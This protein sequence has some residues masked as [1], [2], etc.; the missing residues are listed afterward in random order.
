MAG[1]GVLSNDSDVDGDSLTAVLSEGPSNGSLV[2]N[3][4][5]AFLYTPNLG[6]SGT[7]HFAYKANDG[8]LDSNVVIVS[9]KVNPGADLPP[10][11][12]NDEFTTPENQAL[13]VPAP[14]ILANDVEPNGQQIRAILQKRPKHGKISLK[15][16]GSFVYTPLK[17]FNGIDSFTY[18]ASDGM[19]RSNFATVT[20][21]VTPVNTPPI[22]LNNLY[23]IRINKTLMVAAAGVLKNDTDADGD[24][25][26]ALL[27]KGP[28]HGNLSLSEDGSFFYTP[29]E[30]FFGYD[31]FT[32]QASDGTLHSNS[33]TVTIHVNRP[34]T[35]V[36]DL[37]TVPAS[38][39]ILIPARA[40][41]SIPIQFTF[42]GG[43]GFMNLVNG[44]PV[45]EPVGC[46]NKVQ[47]SEGFEPATG[48]ANLAFDARTGEYSY[49][50]Q[51]KPEW[52]G[53]CRKLTVV[54][55]DG[56]TYTAQYEFH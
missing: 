43:T 24:L 9:V 38:E 32:Y 17:N 22:A 16:N 4:D 47:V 53:T 25:L 36:N 28:K 2:L 31:K 5:G 26:S 55:S 35:W 42:D 6:Y 13:S 11:A 10:V 3:E 7:D 41:E 40:G 30:S 49:A 19:N 27:I 51:T 14:G 56:S 44:Y 23:K 29:A 54:L 52:T 50:W 46:Q 18:K 34:S 39:R 1:P 33:A 15:S 37:F 12:N 45:S 20:I 48:L 8:L 21:I